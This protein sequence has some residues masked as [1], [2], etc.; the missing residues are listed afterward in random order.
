[1]KRI[2]LLV[3]LT[4]AFLTAGELAA[5]PG[6]GSS[7]SGGSSSSSSSTSSSSYSYDS[8]YNSTGNTKAG[9]MFLLFIVISIFSVMFHIKLKPIYNYIAVLAILCL[10]WFIG[11]HVNFL[12]IYGA[13]HLFVL[14]LAVRKHIKNSNKPAVVKSIKQK[15]AWATIE[16]KIEVL[17]QTDPNFSKTLLLD[18]VSL[19]FHKIYSTAGKENFKDVKPFLAESVISMLNFLL[20]KRLYPSGVINEIREI[21]IGAIHVKRI[22]FERNG[23]DVFVFNID[24]NYTQNLFNGEYNRHIVTEKWELR[25][26]SGAKTP[27]PKKMNDLHC[28]NCGAPVNFTDSGVCQSCGSTIKLNKGQWYVKTILTLSHNVI[29]QSNAF[30]YTQERGTSKSTKKS[31]QLSKNLQ[32]FCTKHSIE[33]TQKYIE[34]FKSSIVK[35]LFLKVYKAWEQLEWQT[36]RHLLTDRLWES[37]NYWINMYK[38]YGVINKLDNLKISKIELASIELDNYY[39]TFTLRI[40]ASCK[41]YVEEKETRIFVAGNKKMQREFSEYWTFIR[42]TGINKNLNT[43]NSDHCPNCGASLDK[44][45]QHAICGYCGSKV[46]TGEFSWVLSAITQDEVY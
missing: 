25:R 41:D 18:F 38:D 9:W 29:S 27:E 14:F 40:F 7:F 23:E 13:M 20:V 21:V 3:I 46:S 1:M 8:D 30:T 45:G 24:A 43:I 34:E 2:V 44:M 26:P 4:F 5:R 15:V 11:M 32:E 28:P 6:G 19:L 12:I 37:N 31:K 22:E 36:V 10:L 39:E 16:E 35:P 33:N 42:R 17:K